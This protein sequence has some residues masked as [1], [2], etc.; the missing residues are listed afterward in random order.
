MT[1]RSTRRRAWTAVA[2]IVPAA[3]TVLASAAPV[4]SARPRSAPAWR[5]VRTIKSSGLS[6][7]DVT[8]LSNG[9]A[10]ITGGIGATTTQP[11]LYHRT[12][13][14]WVRILRPNVVAGSEFGADVSA[15]SDTNVWAAI[16]NGSAVDH[17]NGH[18]WHRFS[19]SPLGTS[20]DGVLAFGSNRARVFTFNFITKQGFVHYYN[21]STFTNTLLPALVDGDSSV[22]LVSATSNS[23]IWA[24]ALDLGLHRWETLHFDGKKW[25]V[26]KVRAMI[27]SSGGPAQILALSPKDV[28]GT[29]TANNTGGP[30]L[31]LHWNGIA[32]RKV[33]GTPPAGE[34]LGAI[35]ADGQG[36]VWLS[37]AKPLSKAPFIKPFFLHYLKGKWTSFTAPTSPVGLVSISALALI[38]GTTSLWAVG[39][40]QKPMTNLG[41][42]IEK[43]GP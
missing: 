15:S 6:L 10:W 29:V 11:L 36:G 17:W 1:T 21:G 22:N 2:V 23:N 14:S 32:W 39:A 42:V 43:F 37:A 33:A 34:L 8:A 28:W 5:I 4:A 27:P 30:I 18:A 13:T 26:I 31:L 7:V 12:G 20:I 16:A 24:W 25:T 38:P 41:G 3:V 35:G 19:F 40:I 9:R